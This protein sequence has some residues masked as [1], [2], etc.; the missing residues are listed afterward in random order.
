MKVIYNTI[1]TQVLEENM[2]GSLFALAN[3]GLTIVREKWCYILKYD[4]KG[5]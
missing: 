2:K 3:R 4:V 5:K 1:A